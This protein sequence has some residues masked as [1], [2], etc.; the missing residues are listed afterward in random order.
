MVWWEIESLSLGYLIGPMIYCRLVDLTRGV[1][2]NR[3]LVPGLGI[4]QM[5]Y[6]RLVDL[7]RGV[8][9]NLVLIPGLS[10]WPN[11]LSQTCRLTLGCAGKSS[12]CPWGIGLAQ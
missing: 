7:P 5:I 10:D 2:G 4:G 11:D 12:P 6:R 3:V 9:R 1:L 8:L